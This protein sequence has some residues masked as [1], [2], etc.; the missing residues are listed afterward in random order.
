LHP[1]YPSIYTLLRPSAYAKAISIL[2]SGVID[3]ENRSELKN[4]REEMERLEG[5]SFGVVDI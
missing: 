5:D 1:S 3:R 2:Q 4:L